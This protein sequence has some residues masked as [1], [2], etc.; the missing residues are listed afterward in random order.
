[1]ITATGTA[2]LV[3]M[4]I[5]AE[6]TFRSG[7]ADITNYDE[8]KKITVV[9]FQSGLSLGLLELISGITLVVLGALAYHGIIFN[10]AAALPL[11]ITGIVTVS[12]IILMGLF[13]VAIKCGSK[14]GVEYAK[15]YEKKLKTLTTK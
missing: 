5:G 9:P 7:S 2:F 15:A 13:L 8:V 11:M 6:R 4:G 10:A 12:S 1:M 14:T 3:G